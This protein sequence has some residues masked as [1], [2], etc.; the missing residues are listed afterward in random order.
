[1]NEVLAYLFLGKHLGVVVHIPQ[2]CQC[3]FMFGEGN[4]TITTTHRFAIFIKVPEIFHYS[5]LQNNNNVS[6]V[7]SYL[8]LII[9]AKS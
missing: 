6:H 5:S 1:M 4:K 7:F 9:L 3:M 8:K 2:G